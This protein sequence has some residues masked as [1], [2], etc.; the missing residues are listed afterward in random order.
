MKTP[1]HIQRL[2]VAANKDFNGTANSLNAALREACKKGNEEVVN[3]LIAAEV[4]VNVAADNKG[5]T[6]LMVACAG[7]HTEVRIHEPRLL[8]D[9][10]HVEF[11]MA[12]D[13]GN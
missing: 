3:H 1:T 11:L 13:F 12:L 7:G 5:E 6:A 10:A 8:G 9:T 4:D 2:Q